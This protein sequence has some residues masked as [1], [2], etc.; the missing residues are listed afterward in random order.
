MEVSRR[1]SAKTTILTHFSARYPKL[2]PVKE[3][4]GV[5]VSFSHAVAL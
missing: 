2:P 4:V 3:S 1:A 5:F